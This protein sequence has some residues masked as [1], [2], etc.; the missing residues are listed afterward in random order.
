MLLQVRVSSTA[1][2]ANIIVNEREN[3]AISLTVFFFCF[4]GD[5]VGELNYFGGQRTERHIVLSRQGLS[6]SLYV[7]LFLA[8]CLSQHLSILSSPSYHQDSP[9]RNIQ[10]SNCAWQGARGRVS[11]YRGSEH[12]W[13]KWGLER[14]RQGEKTDKQTKG[15]SLFQAYVL[16][17]MLKRWARR[18]FYVPTCYDTFIVSVFA[19]EF[20]LSW[21]LL[22]YLYILGYCYGY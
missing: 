18:F 5:H 4:C 3:R 22:K 10:Y 20:R 15:S 2:H 12:R 16:T 11:G 19:F 13:F 9:R 6:I 8:C 21:R 14:A 7:L 17:S 1:M